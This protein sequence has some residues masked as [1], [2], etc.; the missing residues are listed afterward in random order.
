MKA[1]SVRGFQSV[2]RALALVLTTVELVQ[3]RVPGEVIL[4]LMRQYLLEPAQVPVNRGGIGVSLYS[5]RSFDRSRKCTNSHDNQRCQAE[6]FMST[7]SGSSR[8]TER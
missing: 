6:L 7:G 3:R 1:L 5:H 8:P 4:D 2:V